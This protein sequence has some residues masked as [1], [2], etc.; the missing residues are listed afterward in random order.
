MSGLIEEVS[1]D[2]LPK[3]GISQRTCEKW[4]YGLAQDKNGAWVQVASY[5][6]G[7]ELV[8]QKLRY[9]DKT[10]KFIGEPK[11]A[12]LFGQHLWKDG[13]KKIV[14]TEGEIDAL[15]VSQ[16]QDN[17]WPVVSVANGADGAKRDIA[18]QLQWLNKFDEIVLM[19][20]TD[21]PKYR[22]DG[23]GPFFPGQEA[24][25]ECALLFP[26]GKCKVASL[27]LKDPNEMLQAGRGQEVI[28]AIWN[29]QTVKPSGALTLKDLR[30][31]IL[32]VP[33]EGLPWCLPTMTSL[34]H[35][36]RHG[37]VYTLGAGTGI[38]KTDLLTQQI[39]FDVTV[40][41][42]PVGILFFEQAPAETG[43]RLANKLAGKTFHIPG[44]GWTQEEL[45]GALDKLEERAPI[46]LFDH[47]GSA[48][49][50]EAREVIRFWCH[51]HGVRVIYIDH[52]TAFAAGAEDER[53]Y[54]EDMMAQ[55]AMLAK[56]LGV[57][58]H[59]VSHLST[60]EGKPHEEGGRVMIK[61]FKG[62][63][64]IGYW[65]HFMIGLERNT[66]A[67][68]PEVQS[69][70]TIRFLKDRNTGQATGKVFHVRYDPLT[71]LLS[72][73]EGPKEEGKQRFRDESG[74]F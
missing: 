52:L 21:E 71:S 37:E 49:W 17:K 55:V 67:E 69:V 2:G 31:D 64:A 73:C 25:A 36:R 44:S 27:P 29:A 13:G 14:I 65:S 70:T 33:E 30:E 34:T 22:P 43:K 24:A 68:D 62:S 6:D 16:L 60:P 12:G 47:W 28:Q 50:E 7:N 8:A 3:R 15:T 45:V 23:T 32:K 9:P 48:N 11:R 10:F 72:E 57:V 56:E 35:G 51:A 1:L 20:D 40:L 58:I 46:H 38:G 5:Y 63:R 61:H 54:L 59:L 18:K 53:K 42:Q 19:F 39:M 41:Q 4:G 74:D 66:Q 26:P